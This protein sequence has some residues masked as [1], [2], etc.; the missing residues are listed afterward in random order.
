[1]QFS[2]LYSELRDDPLKPM[3]NRALQGAYA[4]GSTFKLVTAVGGLEEGI[5]TPTTLIEDTGVYRYYQDYQP[6]CWLYRQYHR[7]HGWLNVT[8]A[9]EVSCNV[10]F[11][12]VG[13]RL[14]IEKIDEYA[15]A[16]GLGEATGVELPENT[17][18]VAGPEYSASVG[19]TWTDGVTLSAA[20]GQSDNRFTPLQL[21]NY[22]AS[23]V[24]GGTRYS[25]HF[26][27]SIWSYDY[28]QKFY[29]YQPHALSTI[30]M[31]ASTLDAVKKGLLAVTQEGSAASYFRGLDYEVGAKTG[32]AQVTGQTNSNAVFVCFAPYDDPQIAIAIVVEKGGSGSELGRIA[33]D[34]LDAY[35]D[36]GQTDTADTAAGAAANTQ[37]AGEPVGA[38]AD[39]E[40]DAEGGEAA[41]AVAGLQDA[42]GAGADTQA[43]AAAEEPAGAD[44]DT[45]ADAAAEEPAGAD[46]DTQADTA[47]EEPAGADAG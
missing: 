19:Q 32:S 16:F 14:T 31:Q 34:I 27:K 2:Q 36:S 13:R 22:L 9:L 28:A 33:R 23:V 38:D 25:A 10:F 6:M 43:D 26:L 30:S 46:A 24:D 18:V 1:S 17:G 21:A 37:T 47:A 4:P 12:D 41:A 3:Y 5:I 7:T 15:R 42:L 44:A 40:A 11:Y 8:R 39:A 29:E 35:F 20:I 45:Q